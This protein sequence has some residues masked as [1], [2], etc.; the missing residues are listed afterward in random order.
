MHDIRSLQNAKQEIIKR[1]SLIT[2][3]LPSRL[4]GNPTLGQEEGWSQ[5]SIPLL[6]LRAW[7]SFCLQPR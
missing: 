4:G 6:S 3:V 7:R 1:F 5:G 2:S